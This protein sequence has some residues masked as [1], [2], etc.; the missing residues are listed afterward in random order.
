MNRDEILK[1]LEPIFQTVFNDDEL[2]VSEDLVFED[3]D[4]WSS[5]LH[6]IMIAEVEKE[7]G[8]SF[9]LREV[10][11]MNDVK[12]MVTSIEEKIR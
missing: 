11:I 2:E 6:T 9:K 12:T 3:I 8:V 4:E 5:I 1:R 10:A 7:F